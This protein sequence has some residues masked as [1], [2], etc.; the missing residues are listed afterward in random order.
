MRDIHNIRLLF[1]RAF[2][3]VDRRAHAL[4]LALLPVF[5]AIVY[6]VYIS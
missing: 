1:Y 4:R 6:N 5:A 2:V 3:L